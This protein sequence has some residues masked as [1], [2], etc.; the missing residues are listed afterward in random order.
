MTSQ[1]TNKRKEALGYAAALD[2]SSDIHIYLYKIY[3][4]IYNIYIY[5]YKYFAWCAD[6]WRGECLAWGL[7]SRKSKK[8]NK[9]S[10]PPGIYEKGA[11][12][13]CFLHLL[14]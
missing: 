3:N 11:K 8:S 1:A 5:I 14:T 9:T 7:W 12:T 13:A 2:G 6:Y 10:M 4:K